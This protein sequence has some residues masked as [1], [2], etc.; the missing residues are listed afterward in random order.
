MYYCIT[1]ERLQAHHAAMD[2]SAGSGG[3]IISDPAEAAVIARLGSSTT[4]R[5]WGGLASPALASSKSSLDT[6]GGAGADPSTDLGAG[7]GA[8]WFK[9]SMGR[10][11]AN[12]ALFP[13]R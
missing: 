3:R 8:A 10:E 13:H 9:P 5:S 2:F 4:M 1:Q 12:S 6:E 11:Q 7:A